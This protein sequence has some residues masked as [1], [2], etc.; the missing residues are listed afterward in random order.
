MSWQCAFFPWLSL[1]CERLRESSWLLASTHYL[2]FSMYNSIGLPFASPTDSAIHCP[3][4]L[5]LCG[6]LE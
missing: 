3:E 1:S 5:T 4:S 2:L 6:K